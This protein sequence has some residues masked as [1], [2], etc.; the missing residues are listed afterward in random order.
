MSR[1]SVIAIVDDDQAM[2]EALYDLLEVEGFPACAFAGAAQFLN[3]AGDFDCVITDVSMPGIDGIELQRRLRAR[4]SAMPVI[5]VTSLADPSA[6]A[7]AM[8]DGASAW[9]AKPVADGALLAALH[10]ALPQGG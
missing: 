5:F 7:C 3:Q 8:R 1:L 6:C 4:G 10:S 9:L 2:R